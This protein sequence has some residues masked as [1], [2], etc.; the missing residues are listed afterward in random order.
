MSRTY[1]TGGWAA[2]WKTLQEALGAAYNTEALRDY[3][4]L[5]GVKG[6]TR[7]PDLAEAIA[8]YLLG[9]DLGV[10]RLERLWEKLDETQQAAVAE[11]LHGKGV[12]DSARFHAKYGK[13]AALVSGQG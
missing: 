3:A 10:P 6:R 7:R 13:A 8:D 4:R 12:F 5:L 2:G 9:A 11:V 1:S